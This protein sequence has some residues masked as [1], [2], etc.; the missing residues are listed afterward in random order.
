MFEMALFIYKLCPNYLIIN[1]L[2]II[3][4]IPKG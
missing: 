1:E 3:K 4:L 2:K